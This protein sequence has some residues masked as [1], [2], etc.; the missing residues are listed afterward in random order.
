M[1]LGSLVPRIICHAFYSRFLVC[2]HRACVTVVNT[3]R[4]A[5]V[6]KIQLDPQDTITEI[7]ADKRLIMVG[8]LNGRVHLWDYSGIQMLDFA[9]K[10]YV[11][12]VS[13]H[14]STIL[15]ATDGSVHIWNLD[16]HRRPQSPQSYN[17]NT[18][19]A[20]L[21]ICFNPFETQSGTPFLVGRPGDKPTWER[22]CRPMIN[23]SYGVATKRLALSVVGDRRR[24]VNVRALKSKRLVWS[25]P[26]NEEPQMLWSDHKNLFVVYL[27]SRRVEMMKL[28][29]L[30]YIP[31]RFE[32]VSL[33]LADGP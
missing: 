25:V 33:L 28:S 27:G 9:A 3:R 10:G 32:S 13:I 2:G 5:L 19:D 7:T 1:Q 11:H 15:A 14:N 4:R 21:W 31:T 26:L 8:T 24:Q 12:S 23:R 30:P 18:Q 20:I 29:R 22:D 16:S 6:K 17:V